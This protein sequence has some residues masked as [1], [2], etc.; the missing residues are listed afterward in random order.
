MNKLVKFLSSYVVVLDDSWED[1]KEILEYS[2]TV[3]IE[4]LLVFLSFIF[5]SILSGQFYVGLELIIV[6]M[7]V[8]NYFGGGHA[9]SF[10]TC[11]T[12]SN[13]AFTCGL[14]FLMKVQ[15]ESTF[16][17]VFLLVSSVFA[18]SR[19]SENLKKNVL[20]LLLTIFSVI[21]CLNNFQLGYCL[22]TSCILTS[23][24]DIFFKKV[25]DT[26]EKENAIN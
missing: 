11:F 23:L 12:I 8:R 17:L 24:A 18:Y 25:G 4:N 2:I 3:L 16:L 5:I 14:L 21:L 15:Q 22:I 13:I 26:N 6:L 9:S 10:R 19:K 1:S 7:L 20:F